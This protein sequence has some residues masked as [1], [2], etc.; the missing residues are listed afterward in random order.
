MSKFLITTDSSCDLN[1]EYYE[2]HNIPLVSLKYQLNGKQYDFFNGPSQKEFFAQMR[3][4]AM[5]T[6]SQVNP[7]EA[8]KLFEP[9]L[10]EG[11]DIL[12]L[13]FTSGLSGTYNSA[14]IAGE[15]LA[16]EYP[17]RKIIVI[18]TLCA[19]MG[20]GLLLHK[21]V[22]LRD[23]GRSME[24]IADWVEN[25]KLH[26]CHDVTVDDLNHLWR[27]GRIS[28][29]TAIIGTMA[30][31]KPIIHVNDEG[32]LIN[33]GKVRGRKKSLLHLVDMMAEQIKDYDGENDEVFITHGDVEEDAQFV[34]NAIRERFGITNFNIQIIGTVIGSHTGPG[35]VAIFFMGT[36]R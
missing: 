30:G 8:R 16:E 21:A 26:L 12:H 23:A 34:A 32:K 33:I 22:K 18:D 7:D 24:E 1:K 9:L 4:G 10:K 11:Y 17:D 19:S 3:A 15:E 35:V 36:K 14:R 20:Q 2:E 13:A 6:T 25:N 31:I 27:G 5:P 28:R 29:S